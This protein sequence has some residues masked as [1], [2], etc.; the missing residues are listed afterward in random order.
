VNVTVVN[1]ATPNGAGASRAARLVAGFETRTRHARRARARVPFGATRPV[2]GR[3]TDAQGRPIARARLDVYATQRRPGATRKQEGVV[4]TN[5]RGRFRYVPRRGPSRRLEVDYRAFSLDPKPSATASLALDVRAGVRLVVRPRR[6][7]SRG[8]IRFVGRLLGRPSRA[9]VQVA[10]YA[11]GREARSRVPVAVVTTDARGRFR[12]RYRFVRTF[13][14]FTYR[15]VARVE[16]QRG[17]PY[18]P[19]G[20][21][22]ALVRVVR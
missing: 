3:L 10:L 11:V 1:G 7:G 9:G 8:R 18:A 17:Y 16:R 13:A 5:A 20:S 4:E 12:Y 6:I 22:V 2:H 19:G 21:P 15:F 14:P